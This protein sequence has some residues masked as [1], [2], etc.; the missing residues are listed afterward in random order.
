MDEREA[1][2]LV[3]DIQ[4]EGWRAETNYNSW[5]GQ[6]TVRA[7]QG[8]TEEDEEEAYRFRFPVE[9]HRLQAALISEREAALPM[10]GIAFSDN[11]RGGLSVEEDEDE[12]ELPY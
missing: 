1:Q 8:N 6:W 5:S 3:I 11:G 9:W 2:R 4:N 7:W 10:F 12:Y